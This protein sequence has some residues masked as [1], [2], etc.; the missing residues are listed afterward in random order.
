MRGA[1]PELHNQ[2]LSGSGR[3]ALGVSRQ[4]PTEPKK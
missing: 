2:V 3:I 1:G 4:K